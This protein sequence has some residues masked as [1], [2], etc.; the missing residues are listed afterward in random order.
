MTTNLGA[1]PSPRYAHAALRY[2][3]G[4]IR[5]FSL[6]PRWEAESAEHL[7]WCG[8]HGR[9]CICM[10]VNR[11][12]FDL[13]LWCH[14]GSR[15]LEV[16]EVAPLYESPYKVDARPEHS[17][18]TCEAIPSVLFLTLKHAADRVGRS[19][20]MHEMIVFWCSPRHVRHPW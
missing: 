9:R 13:V 17:S 19:Y 4:F 6:S 10:L 7:K 14:L 15:A 16:H 2:S 18:L 3:L 20:C 5:E 11:V 8:T 1:T 12:L